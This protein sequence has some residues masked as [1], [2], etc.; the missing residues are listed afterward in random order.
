MS[1]WQSSFRALV[2]VFVVCC[3]ETLAA[4][5]RNYTQ[6]EV[7]RDESYQNIINSYDDKASKKRGLQPFYFTRTNC[8]PIYE[9]K[10]NRYVELWFRKLNR[11]DSVCIH[12]F[13]LYPANDIFRKYCVLK[14]TS[15]NSMILVSNLPNL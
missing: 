12:Y 1:R 8:I 15:I 5:E 10:A 14:F 11:F 2:F 9:K 6:L 3:F 13:F 4:S 7:S